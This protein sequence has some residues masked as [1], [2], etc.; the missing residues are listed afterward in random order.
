MANENKYLRIQDS[1]GGA[2]P[3]IGNRIGDIHI[4]A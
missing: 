3:D 2:H 1:G 4:D